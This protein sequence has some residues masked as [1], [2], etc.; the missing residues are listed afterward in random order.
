MSKVR[1]YELMYIIK[2]DLDE[3]A[4]A[5]VME[6]YKGVVEQNNGEITN[7]EKWGKRRLAYEIKD[8]KDG[9]Y[10]LMNFKGTPDLSSEIDRLLKINDAILRHMIVLQEDV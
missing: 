1:N 2:P 5:A 10:V 9:L 4:A 7:L 8:Y 6:R 3:E